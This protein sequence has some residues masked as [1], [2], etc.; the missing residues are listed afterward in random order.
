MGLTGRWLTFGAG[1]AVLYLLLAKAAVEWGGGLLPIPLWLATAAAIA[2][3]LLGGRQS[4]P[5]IFVGAGIV[6]NVLSGLL[7]FDESLRS[8]VVPGISVAVE[9]VLAWFLL[10]PIIDLS[11]GLRRTREAMRLLA[12]LAFVSIVGASIAAIDTNSTVISD[13]L[14]SWEQWALGEFVGLLAV[15]PLLVAYR[16]PLLVEMSHRNRLDAFLQVTAAIGLTALSF[17]VEVPILYLVFAVMAWI[18]IRFGLRLAAPTALV[19]V[20]LAT[21]L[22]GTGA[23]PFFASSIDPVVQVQVFNAVLLVCTLVVAV[24]ATRAWDDQQQLAATLRAL[25]DA[26]AVRSL[27]GELVASW[28][29]SDLT[30]I[31]DSL[32][33]R[34]PPKSSTDPVTTAEPGS[35]RP[36]QVINLGAHTLEHRISPIDA[37][38]DLHL[39][40]DVTEVSGA[41]REVKKMRERLQLVEAGERKRLAQ[42]LHD[43]PI[44]DL[45]AVQIR[46]DLEDSEALG[47]PGEQRER[48]QGLLRSAI[49]SLRSA[50]S[51]LQPPELGDRSLVLELHHV[52]EQFFDVAGV[53]FAVSDELSRPLEAV[54]SNTLFLVGREAIANVAFHSQA[55]SASI[56]LSEV[57]GAV[58]LRIADDGVGIEDGRGAGGLHLGLQLMKER[59]ED[60][61]GSLFITG[62]PGGGTEVIARLALSS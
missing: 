55:V 6:G 22:S 48:T 16:N 50:A 34:A 62:S 59:M 24:H 36:S 1:G 13:R 8:M 61:D 15:I 51:S 4:W 10:E 29:P 54:E 25:P 18:S 21:A 49:D 43:G 7:L 53:A 12:V 30:F 26:A 45:T 33:L 2:L 58:Q 19:V 9:I 31:E 44:Q 3:G 11:R 37:E 60:V 38:H 32:T 46:L 40:R 57:D 35:V 5:A 17:S 14:E 41:R 28:V 47:V 27:D 56:D 42:A 39:F 52:A 23:G 20:I